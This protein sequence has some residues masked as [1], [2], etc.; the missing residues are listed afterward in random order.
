MKIIA[1]I[2]LSLLLVFETCDNPKQKEIQ[3]SN[4]TANLW[5]KMLVEIPAGTIEKYELNKE[6]GKLEQDSVDGK[7]RLI[8]Y[9]GYPANYGMI[10]E[11]IL[12]K[13]DGGDGDPL[14]I[15]AI[16]PPSKI[17]DTVECKVI[18]ILKLKDRGEQDDKLIA[19]SKNSTLEDVNSLADLK[20]KY[21]GISEIIE[22]WFTNYK[23]QGKMISQGYREKNEAIELYL[24][25]KNSYKGL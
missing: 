19:I 15:I 24:T 8:K 14:D 23:G 2:L 10:P 12:S 11:T 22:I 25:S 5:V 18:G 17:G 3:S 16:G 4:S 7:P 20:L 21:P 1:S 9:I 13:S 6:N